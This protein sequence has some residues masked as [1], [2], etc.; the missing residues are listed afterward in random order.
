MLQAH[1]T[2]IQIPSKHCPNGQGKIPFV[3]GR[4]FVHFIPFEGYIPIHYIY[5]KKLW[6]LKTGEGSTYYML[7]KKLILPI[8]EDGPFEGDN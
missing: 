8:L 4:E 6:K 2:V 1:I 3:R 7:N 5:N